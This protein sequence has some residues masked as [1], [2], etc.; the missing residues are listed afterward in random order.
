MNPTG[1]ADID[2]LLYGKRDKSYYRDLYTL[3]KGNVKKVDR[4]WNFVIVDLGSKIKV[5]QTLAG[6]TFSSILDIPA[7]KTM[8][9]VRGLGSDNPELICKV[10]IAEVHSDY[11]VANIDEASLKGKIKEGDSVVFL[12]DDLD[13]LLKDFKAPDLVN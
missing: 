11:A 9:V 10:L 5:H 2:R 4:K 3:V 8:S 13:S 12:D 7:Q 6:K 1:D